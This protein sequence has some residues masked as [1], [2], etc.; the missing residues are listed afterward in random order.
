[1]SRSPDPLRRSNMGGLLR[2]SGIVAAVTVGLKVVSLLR[3]VFVAYRFGASEQ[4]DAFVAAFVPISVLTGILGGITAAFIPVYIRRAETASRVHAD[5]L[6]AELLPVV[7]R[8]LLLLT[9]ILAA[10]SPGMALLTSGYSPAARDL[11]KSLYLIMLPSVPL[12]ALSALFVGVLNARG[13]FALAGAAPSIVPLVVVIAL[14]LGGQSVTVHLLALA[15]TA[16]FAVLASVSFLAMGSRVAEMS[17]GRLGEDSREVLR[18]FW[19]IAGASVLLSGAPMIDQAMVAG[20]GTGAA[21]SMFF[22]T[23]LV[24]QLAGLA[25]GAVG[26]VLLPFLSAK[27]AR[28]SW[29]ELLSLRIRA[30]SSLALIGALAAAFLWSF[31]DALSVLLYDRGEMSAASIATISSVQRA[32]ALQLPFVLA[33]A[34][35][36][37][38]LLALGLGRMMLVGN[39]LSLIL[40][41]VLNLLLMPKLGVAGIALSTSLVYAIAFGYVAFAGERALRLRIS[42]R[43][44]IV[45]TS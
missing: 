10:L 37:R 43:E 22:G 45:G 26:T 44:P 31:S 5:R 13:E 28:E 19:P 9:F 1:M 33:G 21:A 25:T 16:G 30:V 15:T 38:L 40:N 11:T 24:A 29:E 27:V 6:L 23:K 41:F 18:L 42:V 3:E 8:R 12:A 32:F 34:F 17:S 7:C 36:V 35:Y 4:V 14:A 20:L 39:I 2:A